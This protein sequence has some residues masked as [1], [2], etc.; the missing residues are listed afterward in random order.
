MLA[1]G[2]SGRPGRRWTRGPVGP[3]PIPT[4]AAFRTL[5]WDTDADDADVSFA[6]LGLT[7]REVAKIARREGLSVPSA[8]WWTPSQ[9]GSR[10]PIPDGTRPRRLSRADLQ[11]PIDM[12]AGTL[13]AIRREIEADLIAEQ[14]T[15]NRRRAASEAAEARRQSRLRSGMADVALAIATGTTGEAACTA[16]DVSREAFRAELRRRLRAALACERGGLGS[17]DQITGRIMRGVADRH[18]LLLVDHLLRPDVHGIAARDPDAGV[19]CSYSPDVT[20][21]PGIARWKASAQDTAEAAAG[22]ADA[23]SQCAAQMPERL[24]LRQS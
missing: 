23:L 21:I 4:V 22:L 8:A 6:L 20:A 2:T 17:A 11:R 7:R 14:E 5:I 18:E 1:V 12:S 13:T 19:A 9:Y 15:R 24:R 3:L 10:L 16:Q